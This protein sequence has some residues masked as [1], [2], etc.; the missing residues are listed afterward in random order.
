MTGYELL[1]ILK[2]YLN[3]AR[4]DSFI[5]EVKGVPVLKAT[6][7][8]LGGNNDGSAITEINFID[9]EELGAPALQMFTTVAL[10]IDKDNL[11]PC[12][13]ELNDYNLRYV[14]IGSFNVY[15]PYRQIYHRY[16]QVLI[17]D[18]EEQVAQAKAMLN[19]A[20]TQISACYD[21]ILRYAED[22]R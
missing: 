10:N 7:T 2:D 11:D 17:G 15:K 21:D 14:V 1:E 18:D 3:E 4:I 13:L 9:F 19:V 16:A 6:L 5:T 8:G 20:A 22:A 12:E